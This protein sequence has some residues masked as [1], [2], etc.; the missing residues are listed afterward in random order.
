MVSSN[1]LQSLLPPEADFLAIIVDALDGNDQIIVGQ[2]SS[3]VSGPTVVAVTIQLRMWLVNQ[4]WLIVETHRVRGRFATILRLRLSRLR[5]GQS[6]PANCS[7]VCRSTILSMS[8]GIRLTW[9][10]QGLAITCAFP[11]FR[12]M[13]DSPLNSSTARL[14]MLQPFADLRIRPPI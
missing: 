13:T 3:R 2:R 12:R 9:L 14:Q 4:S 7:L 1:G 11:A 10:A 5:L 6:R 8:I